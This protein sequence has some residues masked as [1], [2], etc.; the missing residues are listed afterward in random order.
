MPMLLRAVRDNNVDIIK[1][2][3]YL[4]EGFQNK[5]ARENG[6]R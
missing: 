2:D 6:K 4:G 1:D 3:T 5:I